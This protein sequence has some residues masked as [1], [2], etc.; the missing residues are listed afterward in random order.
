MSAIE[1]GMD[2]G[3]N[4]GA[5]KSRPPSRA[6]PVIAV[7]EQIETALESGKIGIWS[8]DIAANKINWS[9]NLEE[10]HHLPP[11]SFDG[12]FSFFQNDI[13]PDDRSSVLAAIAESPRRRKP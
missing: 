6:R 8:W 9:S 2:E 10:I 11:G 7:P 12:S 5:N 4:K 1:P 3:E 13:H